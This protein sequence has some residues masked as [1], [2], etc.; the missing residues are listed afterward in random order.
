MLV[1]VPTLTSV[2]QITQVFQEKLQY[3]PKT[4]LIIQDQ[5]ITDVVF[6]AT[7]LN[8]STAEIEREKVD[9]EL[10][11]LEKTLEFQIDISPEVNFVFPSS[12]GKVYNKSGIGKL[13]TIDGVNA[14]GINQ[15]RCEKII[16][17]TPQSHLILRISNM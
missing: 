1:C 11:N 4:R 6:L 16:Q 3:L 14:Y 2:L 5:R 9:F 7:D 8:P 10:R 12:G 13:V 17:S 15:A